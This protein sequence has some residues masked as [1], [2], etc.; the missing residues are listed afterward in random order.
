[1][2]MGAYGIDLV[3]LKALGSQVG[4]TLPSLVCLF[5]VDWITHVHSVLLF[6][7]KNNGC[8]WGNRKMTKY[9]P[10]DNKTFLS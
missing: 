5:S 1:M 2:L 9:L 7:Q 6:T 8:M 10:H 4:Q 3:S